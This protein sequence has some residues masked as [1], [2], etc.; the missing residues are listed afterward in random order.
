MAQQQSTHNNQASILNFI[1][2]QQLNLQLRIYWAEAARTGGECG[3]KYTDAYPIMIVWIDTYITHS[4]TGQLPLETSDGYADGLDQTKGRLDVQVVNVWACLPKND[5][6]F[7]I[8]F[9]LVW[10]H[11]IFDAWLKSSPLET[12][13]VWFYLLVPLG[14]FADT[15]LDLVSEVFVLVGLVKI[16]KR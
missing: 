13:S 11:K 10:N 1:P 14:R 3:W 7:V 5:E 8:I 12:Q 6:K 9:V 4:I 16:L 2:Q 15:F